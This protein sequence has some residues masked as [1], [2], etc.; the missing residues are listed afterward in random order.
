[1]A[2]LSISLSNVQNRKSINIQG[3]G[4]FEVRKLGAGEEYDLSMKRRR[5]M[6][7]AEELT[8]YKSKMDAIEKQSD[9]EDFA[10]QS[11]EV[12]NNLSDEMADI[13]KYELDIYKRCFNDDANGEKASKLLDSLAS[14][15]R[16][17]LF[18]IIFAEE[19]GASNE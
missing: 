2:E 15:E 12:I 16:V 6:R 4:D 8:K 17:K 13:Q 11:L 19:Q 7:I 3:F 5:L 10:T 1:M 9:K 18:E 14:D